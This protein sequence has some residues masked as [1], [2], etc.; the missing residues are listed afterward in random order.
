MTS[1]FPFAFNS[2][3]A[4]RLQGNALYYGGLKWLLQS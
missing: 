3:Q 2:E 4:Y 1:K